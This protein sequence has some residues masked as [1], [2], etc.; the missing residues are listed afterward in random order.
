MAERGTPE[1]TEEPERRPKRQAA[2]RAQ[3]GRRVSEDPDEMMFFGEGASTPKKVEEPI[4]DEDE[5]DLDDDIIADDT[6]ILPPTQ[7]KMAQ[8]LGLNNTTSVQNGNHFR[9][10][11]YA[12]IQ[13]QLRAIE[14]F[15]GDVKRQSFDMFEYKMNM[16]LDLAVDI[17]DR[18]KL[19][20]LRQKLT[21]PPAEFLRLDPS[22][23]ELD[24]ARL[25]GWLRVQYGDLHQPSKD[26]RG[27]QKD[28]TPDSYYIKVKKGIEADLPPVPPKM[29]GKRSSTDSTSYEK[30][31]DGNVV[32]EE[33]PA[34]APAMK[35]RAEYLKGSNRRLVRDYLD[36]LKP[37]YLAKLTKRP[38][39]FEML[40][41]EVRDMWDLEQSHPTKK[42]AMTTTPATGLPVF[43]TNAQSASPAKG[44]GKGKGKGKAAGQVQLAYHEMAAG[45]TKGL[46]EAVQGMTG[47]GAVKPT[48]RTGTVKDPIDPQ[49]PKAP[50]VKC[51]NCDKMGHFARD[52]RLP[53]RRKAG[54]GGAQASKGNKK[55][56]GNKN[57]QGA[58]GRKGK[59]G[60]GSQGEAKPAVSQDQL[61][62]NLATLMDKLAGEW[63]PQGS[64]SAPKN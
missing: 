50:N 53:D 18:M 57:K 41:K 35:A 16:A 11:T 46:L 17:P 51:F 31:K 7:P 38:E 44:K 10:G 40:H 24:F 42:P 9:G 6:P 25:M 2:L 56:G 13:D 45:M 54:K 21:G 27:W 59:K 58:E 3:A 28:D 34:Y 43:H 5:D 33:N 30:D 60:K 19:A 8:T 20:M 15:D 4:P 36:G 62:A 23:Q 12:L 22:L 32:L 63:M 26:E 47:Q 39:S 29:R 52:C 14:A 1:P 64:D 49:V 61:M 48:A 37:E 55:G